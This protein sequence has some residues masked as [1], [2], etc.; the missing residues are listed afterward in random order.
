VPAAI[1]LCTLSFPFFGFGTLAGVATMLSY[2][3]FE[4]PEAP[5]FNEK[6]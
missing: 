1:G 6:L 3:F 2:L 5:D 4:K